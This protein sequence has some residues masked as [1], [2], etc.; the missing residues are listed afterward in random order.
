MVEHEVFILAVVS[1][2]WNFFL[3][4]CFNLFYSELIFPFTCVKLT[5]VNFGRSVKSLRWTS[6][7]FWLSFDCSYIE[8]TETVDY[9]YNL[10]DALDKSNVNSLVLSF[11]FMYGFAL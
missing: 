1:F 3:L 7:F 10:T 6:C 8:Q 9:S 4:C 11:L 5:R 2:I